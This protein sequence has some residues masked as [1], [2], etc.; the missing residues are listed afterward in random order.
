M[1]VAACTGALALDNGYGKASV[2]VA[3]LT[4]IAAVGVARAARDGGGLG[5]VGIAVALA[6]LLHR[7]ALTLLPAW[8]VCACWRCARGTRLASRSTWRT[9]PGCS[10]RPSRSPSSGRAWCR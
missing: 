4:S 5:T 2:E 10:P 3:C 7:S 9:S 8:L 6:L 1:A